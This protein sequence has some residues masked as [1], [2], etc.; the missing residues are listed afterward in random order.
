MF[1]QG[2]F[3]TPDL[4]KGAVLNKDASK[5]FQLTPHTYRQMV[6][7]CVTASLRVESQ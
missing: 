4:K 3:D 1:V 7:D 5:M 6:L 2:I